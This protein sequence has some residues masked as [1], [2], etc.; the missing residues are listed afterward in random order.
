MQPPASSL[1]N[2]P[3]QPRGEACSRIL[4]GDLMLLADGRGTASGCQGSAVRDFAAGLGCDLL[5]CAH[6]GKHHA[7]MSTMVMHGG[8]PERCGATGQ[9]ASYLRSADAIRAASK[10]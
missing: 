4:G 3:P 2:L 10:E 7:L 8:K 1:Q 6:A 9:L 5:G